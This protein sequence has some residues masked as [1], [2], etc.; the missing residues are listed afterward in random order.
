MIETYYERFIFKV[1][2]D[3]SPL[4][5]PLSSSSAPSPFPSFLLPAP[6]PSFASPLCPLA[7][8]PYFLSGSLVRIFLPYCPSALP[9][10][11]PP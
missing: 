5:C 10:P 4:L 3:L 8:L 2:S 11:L 9:A 1:I 6:S 7:S